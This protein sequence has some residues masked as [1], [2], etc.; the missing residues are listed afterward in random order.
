[1]LKAARGS[2]EPYRHKAVGEDFVVTKPAIKGSVIN[3]LVEDVRKLVAEGELSRHEI[4]AR[5]R[6]EDLAVL[7]APTLLPSNWYEVET[8]RRMAE[9]LRDEVGG[10]RNEYLRQRGFEK[11]KK[12]IDSGLYRQMEYLG[13]SQVTR[14]LGAKARFESY[15]RDLR[16]LVTLSGSLLNFATWAVTQDPDHAD[17]YRIE[18]RDAADYPEVLGW[19]TEGLINAM[20]DRHGLMGLWHYERPA[21]DLIIFRMARPV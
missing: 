15:G 20:A 11:G 12:L 21:P 18:V 19:A 17:R 1:L 7:D 10:G 13:R 4:E 16:L 6:P 9:L 8:Y 2:A 5:L 3:D 14:E